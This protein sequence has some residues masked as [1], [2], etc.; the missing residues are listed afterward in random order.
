VQPCG[1]ASLR[2]QHNKGHDPMASKELK[3]MQALRNSMAWNDDCDRMVDPVADQILTALISCHLE[4]P[5]RAIE[6][7]QRAMDEIKS[8]L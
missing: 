1:A 4:M 6:C 5:L 3:I 2:Q 8:K 7:L